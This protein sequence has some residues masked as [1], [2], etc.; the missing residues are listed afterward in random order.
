MVPIGA[1]GAGFTA[2]RLG[3]PLTVT[4]CGVGCLLGSA[5]FARRLP[6]IRAE[7]QDLILAQG[8]LNGEPAETVSARTIS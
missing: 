3:A 6:Q 5:L 2:A 8:M 4:I 7:A 1:L